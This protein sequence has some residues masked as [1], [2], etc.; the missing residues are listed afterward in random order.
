MTNNPAPKHLPEG[1]PPDST[2][3]VS[4]GAPDPH[5]APSS[6]PAIESVGLQRGSALTP[7]AETDPGTRKRLPKLRHLAS[8]ALGRGR[9]A[10]SGSTEA[11]TSET[12]SAADAAEL[13]ESKGFARDSPSFASQVNDRT[14]NNLFKY[15]RYNKKGVTLD[16]PGEMSEYKGLQELGKFLRKHPEA[17][18]RKFDENLTFI[19]KKEETEA[20]AGLAAYYR[21]YLDSDPDAQVCLATLIS[22]GHA[23]T[24]SDQYV[25]QQVLESFGG[26][27]DKYS[28]RLVSGLSELTADPSK[29][30]VVMLDDW[31]LSGTQ[32]AGAFHKARSQM[33]G[34]LEK[35]LDSMEINL[36][37]APKQ[38][39]EA[40]RY[41][42]MGGNG[43]SVRVKAYYA[44]PSVYVTGT[45]SSVDVTRG[46]LTAGAELPEILRIIRP[47]RGT[48]FA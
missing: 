6:V 16:T 32:M 28:G 1:G 3:A 18:K 40:Q 25:L 21:Q 46:W 2:T 38:Q 36:I 14:R 7:A 20:V 29:V 5:A 9:T 22:E 13:L 48:E 10:G 39:L 17:S 30:K 12:V 8:L 4:D 23:Q 11:T 43:R 33:T 24:K 19:G 34:D 15:T 42:P 27:L 44:M 35:Y 37:A 45:H 47:Y 26:D 41:Y 31:M